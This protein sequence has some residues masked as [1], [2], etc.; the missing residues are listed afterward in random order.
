MTISRITTL[1]TLGTPRDTELLEMR[2]E[3]LYPA[4]AASQRCWIV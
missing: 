1:I 3:C 4:D 2:I